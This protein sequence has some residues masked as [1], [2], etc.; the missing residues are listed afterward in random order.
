MDLNKQWSMIVD[1]GIRT[2]CVHKCFKPIAKPSCLI[3]K[4]SPKDSQDIWNHT[5]EIKVYINETKW[6]VLFWRTFQYL[7]NNL[8]LIAFRSRNMFF[9]R[10]TGPNPISTCMW[11]YFHCLW[12]YLGGCI[13][14]HLNFNYFQNNLREI[15]NSTFFFKFL[16]VRIYLFLSFYFN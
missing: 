16:M 1:V 8:T 10:H 12:S 9:L 15:P 6:M 11:P 5:F 13:F 14:N 2:L 4:K 3:P 7:S